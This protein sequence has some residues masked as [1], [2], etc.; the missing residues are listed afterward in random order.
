MASVCK[1]SAKA[2]QAKA[3]SERIKLPLEHNSDPKRN[4]RSS[5]VTRRQ[6]HYSIVK[7]V[8]NITRGC[9]VQTKEDTQGE[10]FWRW[11]SHW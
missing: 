8:G 11:D 6:A 4:T 5:T 9:C 7:I 10:T 1:N 3:K 2:L